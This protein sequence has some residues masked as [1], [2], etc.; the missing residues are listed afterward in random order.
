MGLWLQQTCDTE[1]YTS[2]GEEL[3]ANMKTS[4]QDFANGTLP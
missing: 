1:T 4:L 3:E 2:G